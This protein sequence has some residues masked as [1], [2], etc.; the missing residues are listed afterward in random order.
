MG[1]QHTK[2]T[3]LT[4]T[5]IRY[6]V[7]LMGLM[8]VDFGHGHAM[9]R[10]SFAGRYII[11]YVN[12]KSQFK[13]ELII[14]PDNFYTYNVL[15]P[16]LRPNNCRG[17]YKFENNVFYGRSRCVNPRVSDLRQT[18]NFRN[19]TEE[20]LREGQEVVMKVLLD[21]TPPRSQ[22]VYRIYKTDS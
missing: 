8:L 15:K 20:D 5:A 19:L 13:A 11:E 21:R 6:I 16:T 3:G 17:H 1:K 2:K 10:D 18:I 9:D 12:P 4:S 7:F 14:F 22:L